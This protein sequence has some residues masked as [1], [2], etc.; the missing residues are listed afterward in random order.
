MQRTAQTVVIFAVIFAVAS[1]GDLTRAAEKSNDAFFAGEVLPILETKCFKCHGGEEIEGSLRL[2][3]RA[4]VLEGGDSG[5]AVDLETPGDSLLISAVNYEDLEMPPTGK[6][7][8]AQI[9]VLTRWIKMGMPYPDGLV[10]IDASEKHGPPQVNDENRKFWSFQPVVRP[11]LP[12]VKNKAWVNS[13]IDYFILAKLEEEKLAPNPVAEPR[14]LVRRIYYD[15]IGLPPSPAEA[16][17]WAERIEADRGAVEELV[18]HLLASPHYGERWGRHWLDLVR[19]AE[20]NSYERD[21]AKPEVWR[22][23]DYVI[24]SFNEDK[25]YDQFV[26]EQIAGD[27]L[28]QTSPESIIATGYYRLGRWDD[29]PID[30]ELAWYD[31]MDDVVTTT[32]QVF[33][34]LTMNCARCHDHKLDPIPQEDY[35]RFL[36]FFSNVERYGG[37]NRG[38]DVNRWSLTEIN[39]PEFKQIHDAHVKEYETELRDVTQQVTAIEDEAMGYLSPVEKEDFRYDSN[40][41]DVLRKHVPKD[42]DDAK[43]DH[44]IKLRQRRDALKASPPTSLG[45]ALCVKESGSKPK[46][47]HLLLR[48]N[49]KAQDKEV[50]PGFPQILGFADPEIEVPDGAKTS[51]RRKALADWLTSERN[52]LPARVM[53]NRI[54]Q[55]HFGRGIVPTSNDFGLEGKAPTHPQM[56]DWLAA[57]FVAEGWSVKRLHKLILLSSTYQQSSRVREYGDRLDKDNKLLWRFDMRRLSAEELRDSIL[58]VNGQIN[59]KVGGPSVFPVIPKEVLA[60]QSRPGSGWNVSAPPERVRRSIYIHVKRSL[61]VPLLENHD[62]ADVDQTCPVRFNTTVPAQALGLLNSQFMSEQAE[63]FAKCVR[64]EAGEKDGDRVALAL[65]RV[66]QREP[67][68]KEIQRGVSLLNSL[69]DEHKMSEEQAL[70]YFCLVALNLNEFVYLD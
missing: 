22:Y 53:V 7:P 43:L 45:R 24:R 44:Y 15:L 6:L 67:T 39:T 9:D 58:A 25:P 54:W 14:E 65:S 30:A 66:T 29:E 23:R 56:L 32:S 36:S 55:Y 13:P 50:Q 70:K 52:P 18:D 60:G 33:L 12:S 8:Q 61:S 10:K 4:H 57:E 42:L 62:M 20:T 49:H 17:N 34:G 51:Y 69:R 19:Y 5:S 48:G 41:P 37:P 47:M 27:E 46:P 3:S 28:E 2:T 38:R 26:R 16:A 63:E 40:R 64:E 35:Y 1:F 59:L 11:E 21:D 68:E 31:D